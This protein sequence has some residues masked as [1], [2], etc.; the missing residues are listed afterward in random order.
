VHLPDGRKARYFYD[1]FGRRVRKEVTPSPKRALERFKEFGAKKPAVSAI[2]DN[3]ASRDPAS[4]VEAMPN[5]AA[6][7]VEDALGTS[8]ADAM[9][10]LTDIG[11]E[12]APRVTE[13][14]WDGDEIAAELDTES[15]SRGHVHYPGTFVPLLQIEK[16]QIFVVVTDHLGTPRDLLGG[17]GMVRWSASYTAWGKIHEEY[18]AANTTRGPPSS[19]TGADDVHTALRSPFRLLGQYFDEETGLAATRFRMWEAETGRWLSPD[20][21]GIVGGAN[22]FGLAGA[23]TN[24]VDPWGLAGCKYDKLKD[25]APQYVGEH[26][27]DND[28]WPGQQV[29]YLTAAERQAYR[30]TIRDGL[31]YDASGNLFDTGS[32]STVHSGAGRAIFVMDSQGNIYASLHQEVG[33]FHHSSLLAGQPVAGAGEIEVS[34]GVVNGLTRKSGHYR[35]GPEHQA[36]VVTEL[37][38]HGVDMSLVDLGAF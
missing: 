29:K 26:L 5:A 8:L 15:G 7:T 33:E 20:P 30:L 34:N 13:F 36:Q 14:I 1:A 21:L 35:P 12:L 22:L 23:P 27:P 37:Q 10:Q 3:A 17:D 2:G 25:L 9:Q 32:A 11:K 4:V 19:A 38:S 6:L 31:V 18:E 24:T 28:V 16:G